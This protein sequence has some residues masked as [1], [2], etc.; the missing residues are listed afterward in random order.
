MRRGGAASRLRFCW[1]RALKRLGLREC[2]L[3]TGTPPRLDG[4]TI[5][6]TKFEEQPGDADP[7][8]FCFRAGLRVERSREGQRQRRDSS[9]LRMTIQ[10]GMTSRR[11]EGRPNDSQSVGMDGARGR[12]E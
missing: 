7:T 1:A 11:V 3:K 4:R 9:E 12:L 2:R 10:R 6:W 8:P 5:D